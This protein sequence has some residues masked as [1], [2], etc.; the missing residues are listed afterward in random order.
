MRYNALQ[1]NWLYKVINIPQKF[2][3]DLLKHL[4]LR[5]K[6]WVVLMVCSHC[7]DQDT[8]T[9]SDGEKATVNGTEIN[10]EWV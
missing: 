1:F 2:I 6:Q 10:D 8:D 9:D 7:T 4:N 3:I 5:L